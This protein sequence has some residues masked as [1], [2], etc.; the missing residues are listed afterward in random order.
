MAHA[1]CNSILLLDLNYRVGNGSMNG[2]WDEIYRTVLQQ[3]CEYLA[4]ECW[5]GI[6]CISVESCPKLYILLNNQHVHRY[7]ISDTG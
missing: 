4:H 1:K 3:M 5:G 7:F 2:G 6:N